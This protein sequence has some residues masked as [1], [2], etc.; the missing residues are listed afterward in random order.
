MLSVRWWSGDGSE[1]RNKSVNGLR[2]CDIKMSGVG[3]SRNLSLELHIVQRQVYDCYTAVKPQRRYACM[4]TACESIRR[5]QAFRL[6]D[7][8]RKSD[9]K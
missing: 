2:K 1:L 4:R 8:L 6:F 7:V 3:I 9:F 5:C